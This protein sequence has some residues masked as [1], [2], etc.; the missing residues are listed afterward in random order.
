MTCTLGPVA[1]GANATATVIVTAPALAA[2]ASS[3]S[4]T[5]TVQGS[6][7]DP[8]PGNNST[9]AQSTALYSCAPRPNV[10]QTAAADG[11]G[12]VRVTVT[13]T[14]SPGAPANR[15]RGIQSGAATNARIEI[16]TQSRTTPFALP[17]PNRPEQA[18]FFVRRD[19]PGAFTAPF[20]VIDDC[21]ARPSFAGGG[22]NVP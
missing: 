11:S 7:T 15:L 18:T 13:A 14:S 8:V 12:R 22:V 17:L 2:G 21:G 10:T 9:P 19:A 4:S 1:P 3:F 16:D 20:V 6:V 5:A